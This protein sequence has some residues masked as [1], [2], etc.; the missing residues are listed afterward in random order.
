MLQVFRK[1]VN[2]PRFSALSTLGEKKQCFHEYVQQRRNEEKEEERRKAR[3][4]REDFVKMLEESGNVDSRTKWV[5]GGG[6]LACCWGWGRGCV[7]A[8]GSCVLR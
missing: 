8:R 5:L 3:Q 4:A 2:D 6:W 7:P 1:I